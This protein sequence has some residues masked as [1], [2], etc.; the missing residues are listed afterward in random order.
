MARL[1][2]ARPDDAA[3]HE[4]SVRVFETLARRDPAPPPV[5]WKNLGVAYHRLSLTRPEAVAPMV[6]AWRRYLEVAPRTDPDL[7]NIRLLVDDG[8]RRL[9]ESPPTR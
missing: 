3:A 8:A 2:S 5:V 1:A 7:T 9:A 6:R 4:A